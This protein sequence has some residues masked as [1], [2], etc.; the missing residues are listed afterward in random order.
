VADTSI[1]AARVEGDHRQL[2]RPDQ[3]RLGE[4]VC[5][6][7]VC[8][9]IMSTIPNR[10][11]AT[12]SCGG[13]LFRTDRARGSAILQGVPDDRSDAESQA[14]G[15]LAELERDECIRLLTLTRF[16]RLAVSPPEWRTPPV[17]RPVTYVFDRSSQ[18]IVFRSARGSK[19]TAMLLSG[20]AAFEIDGIEPA[21]ETGWS[22]IVQGPIE[23]ITNSA[24][25][26]RLERLELHPWAPGEKP[27]WVRIRANVV[28][29]RR[30]AR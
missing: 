28:S 19:F 17:I 5:A 23:E 24:E 22:V 27:H 30:I 18:S 6:Y 7:H 25:I 10:P 21:A 13:G 8:L 3:P 2:T 9:P 4:R 12:L 14:T 1:G 26:S 16:G 20:Q 11:P 15:Q 29:G